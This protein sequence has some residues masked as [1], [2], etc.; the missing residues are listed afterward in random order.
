MLVLA[1]NLTY[2]EVSYEKVDATTGR[3]VTTLDIP[4]AQLLQAKAQCEKNI[5][6]E[7]ARLAD[8]NKV[9]DEM[10]NIGVE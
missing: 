5:Q 7:Q 3:I 1:C 2:A 10:K 4:I 8:I 9:I 6:S